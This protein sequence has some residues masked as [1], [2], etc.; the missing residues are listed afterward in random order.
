MLAG[1][2]RVL[3]PNNRWRGPCHPSGLTKSWL[4]NVQHTPSASSM[5]GKPQFAELSRRLADDELAR[6]AL[7]DQLVPAAQEALA[8]DLKT[9]RVT[10]LTEYRTALEIAAEASSPAGEAEIQARMHRA[11]AESGLA[12]AAW[13]MAAVLPYVWFARPNGTVELEVSAIGT[14]LVALSCYFGLRAHRRGSR[15]G[16]LLKF[17]LPLVILGI[18]T[19]ILLRV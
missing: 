13:G 3:P 1:G 9:R 5:Y 11:L 15:V 17:A 4:T 6:I 10:D 7:T 12:V 14:V 16:F 18:S 19:A 8:E 2:T